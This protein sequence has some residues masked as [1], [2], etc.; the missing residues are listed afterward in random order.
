MKENRNIFL[1]ILLNLIL[2]LLVVFISPRFDIVTLCYFLVVNATIL[3]LL[4]LNEKHKK[5][6]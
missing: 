1:I 2:S 3:F 4:V 6:K 5:M